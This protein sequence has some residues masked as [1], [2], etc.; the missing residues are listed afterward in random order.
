MIGL[1]GSV[2]VDGD[3]GLWDPKPNHVMS[4]EAKDD[5]VGLSGDDRIRS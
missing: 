2:N 3:A 5:E 1:V 4:S